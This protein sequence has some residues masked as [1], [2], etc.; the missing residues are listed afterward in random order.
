MCVIYHSFCM[1]DYTTGITDIKYPHSQSSIAYMSA[2][3]PGCIHTYQH[4]WGFYL[5]GLLGNLPS[6]TVKKTFH[7]VCYNCKQFHPTNNLCCST[8]QA[9]AISLFL[10]WWHQ[11]SK[12]VFRI[13]SEIRQSLMG[14]EFKP[15]DDKE[16][17][18]TL[19]NTYL[20]VWVHDRFFIE[21]KH[22][23]KSSLYCHKV[24]L[25]DNPPPPSAISSMLFLHTIS[26]SFLIISLYR[27][28][29]TLFLPATTTRH[30]LLTYMGAVYQTR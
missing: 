21:N 16:Q 17:H 6:W 14:N 11:N 12:E 29:S 8:T 13:I 19:K 15:D 24:F 25:P 7:N 10:D 28:A 2:L 27:N 26:L 4:W 18:F 9:Y 30:C 20:W 1:G 23:S 3:R 5:D 22:L